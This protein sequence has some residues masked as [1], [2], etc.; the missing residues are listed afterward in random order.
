M[1]NRI[2]EFTED[3]EVIQKLGDYPNTDDGMNADELKAKFDQASSAIKRFLNEQVV[4]AVQDLQEG[5]R[6]VDK[7][8]TQ[9]GYF[10]DAKATGE[11]IAKAQ[12]ETE[13]KM[14]GNVSVAKDAAN[15]ASESAKNASE[16]ANNASAAAAQAKYAAE[17]VAALGQPGEGDRAVTFNDPRNQATGIAAHAEGEKTVASGIRSHAEG[18][19]TEASGEYTHAE[20]FTTIASG[21]RSHAEG[22]RTVASGALSHAEGEKTVASGARSHAEGSETVASGSRS[23]AEGYRTIAAS[24][25]QHVQG[26][27]NVEDTEGRYAHIIGGGTSETKRKNIHKVDWSGNAWFAG[28]VYAGD[29][30]LATFANGNNSVTAYPNK[31]GIYRTVGTNIF[32]NLSLVGE[33]LYGVLAIFEA[34]YAL[35]VYVDTYGNLYWGRAGEGDQEPIY[36]NRANRY[37]TLSDGATEWIDPPMEIGVEYRTTERHNGNAVYT[38]LVSCGMPV[39]DAYV[40]T[41]ITSGEVIRFAAKMGGLPLPLIYPSDLAAYNVNVNITNISSINMQVGSSATLSNVYCQIWY[42]K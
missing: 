4:P 15:A 19:G 41:G 8:L 23:H 1:D 18:Y 2:T 38:K 22:D 28:N 16:A 33:Q 30:E 35:H 26:K 42:T 12:Q 36:W 11:A 5:I 39:N 24:S 20:G 9:D 21:N 3:V 27:Y 40:S 13:A 37:N 31:A 17:N 7:T 25:M 29:K 10:A 6:K 34:T 32:K 14:Q